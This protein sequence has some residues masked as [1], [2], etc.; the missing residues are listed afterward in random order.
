M[1]FVKVHAACTLQV[2]CNTTT[3]Y[4]SFIKNDIYLGVAFRNVNEEGLDSS[5]ELR[6]PDEEVTPQSMVNAMRCLI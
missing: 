2:R 4:I 5:V 3:K 6:V 1:V